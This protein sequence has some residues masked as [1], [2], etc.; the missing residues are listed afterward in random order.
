MRFSVQ[1]M[2]LC[3]K[4]RCLT[5][6]LVTPTIAVLYHGGLGVPANVLEAESWLVRATEQNCALAW[7]NLGTLYAMKVPDLKHRWGDAQ[8]CWKRAAELGFN[9]ADS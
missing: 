2:L 8:R 3:W 6:L 4:K 9:C 5:R 7:H 1:I